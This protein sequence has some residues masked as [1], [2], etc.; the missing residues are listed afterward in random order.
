MLERVADRGYVLGPMVVELD[1]QIRLADPLLEAAD[2]LPGKLAE[3]TGGTVL[4]C[5]FHGSKVMC[6]HQVKGRNPALS[7][8]YERGR[9]MPLYRGA[10]SKIILAYLPA[11]AAQAALGLRTQDAG[12]RR[13]ARRLHAAGQGAARHTR[14]RPLHHRRRSRSLTP[15]VLRWRCATANT[16][17]AASA[18]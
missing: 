8:S 4:L 10:T 13:P 16:C 5:R 15:W 12:G 2:E 14:G 17:W 7:V 6:I 9:A 3:Q 11:A 18:W 1:R